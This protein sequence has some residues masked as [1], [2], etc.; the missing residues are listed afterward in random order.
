MLFQRRVIDA[1]DYSGHGFFNGISNPDSGFPGLSIPVTDDSA[2]PGVAGNT[3]LCTVTIDSTCQNTLRF[4]MCQTPDP[5]LVFSYPGIVEEY[6]F[7]T[8]AS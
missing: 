4:V 3:Y 6:R 8:T 1:I 7:Y 5:C 2:L